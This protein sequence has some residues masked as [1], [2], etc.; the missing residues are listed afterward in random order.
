MI[1]NVKIKA[2]KLIKSND[3]NKWGTNG[4]QAG[5]SPITEA[6]GTVTDKYVIKHDMPP[7]S[8]SQSSL[9]TD[10]FIKP[11]GTDLK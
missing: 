6:A 9:S 1:K 10:T 11:V 4:Y 7:K 2:S 8:I 5:G 3:Y